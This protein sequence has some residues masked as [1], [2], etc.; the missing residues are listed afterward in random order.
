MSWSELIK[1]S[2]MQ[3]R[4]LEEANVQK[5]IHLIQSDQKNSVIEAPKITVPFGEEGLLEDT[6]T[7]PFVT[8]VIPIVTDD[9]DGKIISLGYQ[10]VVT[11]CKSG[12]TFKFKAAL[13][14]DG[15]C[16]LDTCQFETSRILKV[17][18]FTFVDDGITEAKKGT[19]KKSGITIQQPVIAT[20]SVTAPDIVVPEGMSVL[21]TIGGI[22][23]IK[24]NG[25]SQ[26]MFLLLTPQVRKPW[27]EVN[28]A[29]P[30]GGYGSYR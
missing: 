22:K 1:G 11:E 21:A 4:F 14:E 28:T 29:M 15:S 30:N 6:T 17:H 2:P 9:K 23:E 5:F 24:E 19:Q 10:P 13:L 25:K 27:D 7:I 8:N 26:M 20:F 16:R 12:Q 18:E 3:V